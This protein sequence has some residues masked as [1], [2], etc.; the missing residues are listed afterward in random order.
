MAGFTAAELD[1]R[2]LILLATC[3]EGRITDVGPLLDEYGFEELGHII[4]ALVRHILDNTIPL[5]WEGAADMR[6]QYAAAVR[7]LV[8]QAMADGATE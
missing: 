6:M 7:R 5:D 1:A 3:A 2:A 8:L 4:G